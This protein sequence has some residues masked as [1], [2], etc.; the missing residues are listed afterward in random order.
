MLEDLRGYELGDYTIVEKI[1]GSKYGGVYNC[2]KDGNEYVMRIIEGA[3]NEEE[4][5]D[6]HVTALKAMS[7]NPN[8]LT[9]YASGYNADLTRGG[10]QVTKLE[11]GVH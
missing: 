1:G 6:T 11:G 3:Y 5:F 4:K 9:Y 2:T 7:D 8:F 10:H